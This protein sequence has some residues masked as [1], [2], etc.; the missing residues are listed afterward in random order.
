M[1]KQKL[2]D[3]E[4]QAELDIEP[5]AEEVLPDNM[6]IWNQV[7]ESDKKY[8][9]KVSYG[10]RKFDTIAAYCQFRQATE[11][12]GP[13]GNGWDITDPIFEINGEWSAAVLIGTASLWYIDEGKK[14]QL[15]AETS[16]IKLT[17][18]NGFID[19][20]AWKKLKT[21]LT[22][23]S[24]SRMG[25]NA[26][27]FMGQLDVDNKYLDQE[28]KRDR[29][30]PEQDEGEDTMALIRKDYN[31]IAKDY[32]FEDDMD[33]VVRRAFAKKY[34]KQPMRNATVSQMRLVVEEIKLSFMP[35]TEEDKK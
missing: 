26:D 9:K 1:S 11:L 22:T 29:W 2:T 33:G 8:V 4:T 14:Y 18:K 16:A 23:K 17:D 15:S 25:F 31:I 3:Q 13:Q 30:D 6:R 28:Q 7:C 21:E 32:G 34:P 27:V 5:E 24:L 19:V 20:E 10:S 12:W 35:P